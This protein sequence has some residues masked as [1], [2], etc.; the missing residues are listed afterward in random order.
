[1]SGIASRASG[2]SASPACAS[3][4]TKAWVIRTS[5]GTPS[6]RTRRKVVMGLSPMTNNTSAE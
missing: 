1:V 2:G 6:R 5:V 3:T 4:V